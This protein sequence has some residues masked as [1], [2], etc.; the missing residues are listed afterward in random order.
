MFQVGRTAKR[1]FRFVSQ[2]EHSFTYPVF[3]V[4]KQSARRQARILEIDSEPARPR[5]N[6]LP[7]LFAMH[8]YLLAHR[9][10]SFQR[11][12]DF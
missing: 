2:H 8:L 1:V 7:I 4:V 9:P 10:V 5:N 3:A 11:A 6:L 12:A